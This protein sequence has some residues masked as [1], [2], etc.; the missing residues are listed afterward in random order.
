MT[1]SV[2]SSLVLRDILEKSKF[3]LTVKPL[4]D[5]GWNANYESFHCVF[6]SCDEILERL[7][8]IESSESNEFDKETRTQEKNIKNK[9]ISHEFIVLLKFMVNVTRTTNSMT[10]HLQT[11][12]LDILSLFEL[13]TNTRKLI[14]KMKT[15]DEAL[16]DILGI[17]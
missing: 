15:D 8:S 11:T 16:R 7:E 14:Q 1:S 2:K 6:E 17:K 13:I 12:E 10:I 5:I 3:G 9:L 4:S